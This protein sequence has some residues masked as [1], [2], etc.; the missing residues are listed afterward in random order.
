MLLLIF[1]Y[2]I[3][4]EVLVVCAKTLNNSPFVKYSRALIY[5]RN[6]TSCLPAQNIFI[7]EGTSTLKK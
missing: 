4:K 7:L 1:E 2:D 5:T 3:F 6:K